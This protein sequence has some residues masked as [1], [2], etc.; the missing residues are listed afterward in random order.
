MFTRIFPKSANSLINL[1]QAAEAKA[2]HEA[3]LTALNWERQ[4]RRIRDAQ[5]LTR[6]LNSGMGL[7]TPEQVWQITNAVTGTNN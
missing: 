7:L 5:E 3:A 4:Q 1:K 2:A 6:C